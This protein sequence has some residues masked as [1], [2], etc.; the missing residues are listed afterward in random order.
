ML[1]DATLPLLRRTSLLPGES[2]PSLLE[3]LAQLNHYSGTPVL[4]LL[5]QAQREPPLNLDKPACP[6]FGT[7]F[8][9]LAHLTQLPA[10]E[11]WAASAH[12]FTPT[13]TPTGGAPTEPPW[14]NAA[15]QPRALPTLARLHLR[16]MTTAQYCPLCLQKTP[17][18]QLNWIPVAATLCL[19]HQCLLADRCP[20][21]QQPV[22]IADVVRR[23][24]HTCR[25][26]LSAAAAVLVTGDDLGLLAQQMIQFWF[27]VAPAPTLDAGRQLPPQPPALLYRL[28]EY[29]SRRLLSCRV[30]WP[31]WPMPVPSLDETTAHIGSRSHRLAPNQAYELFRATFSALLDWPQGLFRYLDAYGGRARPASP[32]P[33]RPNRLGSIQKDWLTPAWRAADN[34][35]CIQTWVDY[36]C[37]RQLPFSA[38]LVN[39]LKDVAWFVDKTGLWTE[40]RV[41]QTLGLARQDLGRFYPHGPLAPCRWPLEGAGALY[42][43]RAK[44]L[45]VHQRWQAARGWSL[46]D[47][48][49][50][51]GL[52]ESTVLLLVA[53]GLLTPLPGSAAPPHCT[54]DRQTVID[55]FDRVAA[56]VVFSE[57][58]VYG[59]LHLDEAVR[60]ISNRA[61]DPA[62]LLHAALDGILSAYRRH[63][64]LSALSHVC[65][66]DIQLIRRGKALPT[67]L[68][69]VSALNFARSNNLELKTIQEWVDAG[70]IQPQGGTDCY[71]EIQ[72]LK[73]LAKAHRA[74]L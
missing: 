17:Y 60:Y 31:T 67:T 5:C 49:Y 4:T 12:R 18:H 37:D 30:I 29:L 26:D 47:A 62:T 38:S 36:L 64:E 56:C 39:Q 69:W 14:L 71:F 41:A 52:P 72:R 2:L 22:T 35:F 11:L 59:L 53:R 70:L 32:K 13:L 33:R 50:W 20:G 54:F 61:A 66:V 51:L 19:E 7:T 28:V 63:P 27:A 57:E 16:P 73:E 55:F 6:L 45:A 46:S 68:G 44:V 42:F 48:S 74:A 40:Q 21:C 58:H 15:N 43:D 3:R 34:D 9:R 23:R 24:C 25:T 8:L 10:A 1:T 65:F